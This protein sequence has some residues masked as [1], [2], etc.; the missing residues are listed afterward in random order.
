MT[1]K[2]SRCRNQEAEGYL[3]AESFVVEPDQLELRKVVD[4]GQGALCRTC[5]DD[6]LIFGLMRKPRM[7]LPF[8]MLFT[9][10][11]LAIVLPLTYALCY[12]LIRI[13]FPWEVLAIVGWIPMV[14]FWA[15]V[16]DIWSPGPLSFLRG[17]YARKI[18][19]QVA[20]HSKHTTSPG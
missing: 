11:W 14:I 9:L 12:F 13:H 5:A 10:L 4:D 18:K 7:L 1:I 8:K 20:G 2:C 15:P 19:E 3:R 17:F 6:L 16:G